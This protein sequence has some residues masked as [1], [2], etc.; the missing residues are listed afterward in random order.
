ML[1]ILVFL[2]LV[3]LLFGVGA[4]IHWLWIIAVVA[5]I[6]WLVGFVV[7]SGEGSR[8]YRW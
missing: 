8:W 3:A 2:L 1:P 5:L 6:L 4:A 7:R